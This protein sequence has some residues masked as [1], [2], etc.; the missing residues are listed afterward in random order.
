MRRVAPASY[1]NDGSVFP[2]AQFREVLAGVINFA[3]TAA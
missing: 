1:S 3:E 2:D